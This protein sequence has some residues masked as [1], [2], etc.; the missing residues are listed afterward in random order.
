MRTAKSAA[1]LAA[2]TA[3]MLPLAACAQDEPEVCE[4]WDALGTHEQSMES[5][6]LVVEARV[7]RE[8]MGREIFGLDATQWELDI[9]QT[10]QGDAVETGDRLVVA[11]TPARCGDIAYPDGDA[12]ED[13]EGE[14]AVFYLTK[15]DFGVESEQ[16]W[17]ALISPDA[18]VDATSD[19]RGETEDEG[20]EEEDP[21]ESPEDDADTGEDESSEESVQI[22]AVSYFEGTE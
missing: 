20:A 15:T 6:E 2:V 5:S 8:A 1:T 12:I 17:W 22:G 4:D 21:E 11:S 3:I 19:V 7:V 16:N 10:I 13:R 14:T 9:V 18:V